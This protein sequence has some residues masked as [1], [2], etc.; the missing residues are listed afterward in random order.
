MNGGVLVSVPK[1]S[2]ILLEVGTNELE[3]MEFRIDGR[4]FGINVAK[5]TEVMKYEEITPIPHANPFIEGIFKPRGQI[6]TVLNL[7]SYLGLSESQKPDWD[8]LIITNFNKNH[9]AFHVH[10]IENIHKIS[11]TQIEKPDETITGGQDGIVTGIARLDGRLITILDF[12]KIM[13]EL[14]PAHSIKIQDLGDT[15]NRKRSEKPIFVVEDSPFLRKTLLE[16][17]HKANYVN[18][19]TF[20]TGQD[21]WDALS[22]LTDEDMQN[23]N[24]NV[25]C[26]VTDIEMPQMDG[27]T[28]CKKIKDHKYLKQ[29]PVIMFS[30]LISEEMEKKGRTVGADAQLSKPEIAQ[31]VNLI[32]KFIL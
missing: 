19:L 22:S 32:D 31:L 16:C 8:I 11:W 30:S 13:A 21:S 15:S 17:L 7:P 12:E 18:T 25:A 2:N 3:V 23:L 28:L 27:H 14:N 24:E 10:S 9:T 6:I 1:M 20:P 26:V 29:L 4:S 5:V